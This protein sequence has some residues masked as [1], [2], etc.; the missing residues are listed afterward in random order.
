MITTTSRLPR[1]AVGHVSTRTLQRAPGVPPVVWSVSPPLPAGLS[2]K[3][4]TGNMTGIPAVGTS[5]PYMNCDGER[6]NLCRGLGQGVG[7][8]HCE[9][10]GSRI[11]WSAENGPSLTEGETRGERSLRDGPGKCSRPSTCLEGLTIGLTLKSIWQAGRRDR[12][13]GDGERKNL[14]RGLGQGV[15]NLHCEN[16][17]S[18]ISWSAENGPSLTEGETRGERSLRDGPGKCSRP[19]T[20]LEGLTIGLTLKSI[21]QAGRRDRELG[22]GERKNLC[23]GLGQGVGNLH[24]ENRGSRISWSAENGPSLTEG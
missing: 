15:G 6:K 14:C 9:D 1:A 11:S 4:S 22:D 2:L 18:R 13:L 20:C 21:W 19:S 7:N 12:E 3:T 5:G 24:C 16:R 23:R 8:L 10:R 17:G